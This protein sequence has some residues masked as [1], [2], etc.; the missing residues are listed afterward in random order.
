M[1]WFWD[2][3]LG[4]VHGACWSGDVAAQ[5]VAC[6][7]RFAVAEWPRSCLPSNSGTLIKH[8]LLIRHRRRGPHGT[9]LPQPRCDVANGALILMHLPM[10][11]N[12][13]RNETTYK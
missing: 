7:Q 13:K 11:A 8:V 10:Q 9:S 3:C 4:P 1:L 12:A 2:S 6:D 5:R